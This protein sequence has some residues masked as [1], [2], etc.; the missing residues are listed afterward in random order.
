MKYRRR[1][2]IV[3]AEQFFPDRRPHPVG[4]LD[5]GADD[6]GRHVYTVATANGRVAVV[7]GDWILT[8]VTGIP[9]PCK[10]DVFSA[11]YDPVGES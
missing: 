1:P 8:D 2:T 3:E 11:T 10:P 4:V 7:A 5:H 6:T 9:Y